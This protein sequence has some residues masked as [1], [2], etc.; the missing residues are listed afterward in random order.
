VA[1][2]ARFVILILPWNG[3]SIVW[4]SIETTSFVINC[5]VV[6]LKPLL[7][8]LVIGHLVMGCGRPSIH[9]VLV[10]YPEQW[11]A[12]ELRNCEL[13]PSAMNDA[14]TGLSELDCDTEAHTT[15]RSRMFTMDVEFSGKFNVDSTAENLWTCEKSANSLACKR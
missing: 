14:Q 15:P 4:P 13:L 2:V 8:P 11:A 1:P 3:D 12:G 10:L 7:A 6:K 9:R 5:G